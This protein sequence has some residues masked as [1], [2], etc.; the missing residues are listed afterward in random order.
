MA[1]TVADARSRCSIC[2]L[3]FLAICM[4]ERALFLLLL[5]L[6]IAAG[7]GGYV[8]CGYIPSW[9][10]QVALTQV[11][12]NFSQS[13]ADPGDLR[14]KTKQNQYSQPQILSCMQ[15]GNNRTL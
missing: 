4:S 11:P 15:F 10:K 7:R 5:V 1:G 6:E 14:P 2:V 3:S 13:R 9:N 8:G 12:E